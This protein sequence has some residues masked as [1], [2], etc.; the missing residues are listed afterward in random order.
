V[1]G[2]GVEG[3]SVSTLHVRAPCFFGGG[4][5]DAKILSE[6]EIMRKPHVLT[7][8]IA[9]NVETFFFYFEILM[10]LLVESSTRNIPDLISSCNTHKKYSLQ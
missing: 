6:P 5:R 3:L 8:Q 7:R 2:E 4:L 9:N 10:S 1:G